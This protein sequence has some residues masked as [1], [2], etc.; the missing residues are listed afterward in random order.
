MQIDIDTY[1]KDSSYV[2]LDI[3]SVNNSS[4]PQPA[5]YNKDLNQPFIYEPEKYVLSVDR[6]ELSVA[7]IVMFFAQD[8]DLQYNIK[9]LL[10]P[11]ITVGSTVNLPNGTAI[12]SVNTI[13]NLLNQR[14]A[15]SYATMAGLVPALAG[16][17]PYGVIYDSVTQLF[18]FYV[19]PA[20]V[21]IVQLCFNDQLREL[22]HGN[23]YSISSLNYCLEFDSGF[24]NSNVVTLNGNIYW[25]NMANY[26][27]IDSWYQVKEIVIETDTLPVDTLNRTSTSLFQAV[28]SNNVL[29]D[30]TV[31]LNYSNSTPSSRLIYVPLHPRYLNFSKTKRILDM[32][33]ISI[34]LYYRTRNGNIFPLVL[35]PGDSFSVLLKFS[36]CIT[37]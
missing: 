21:G 32:K 26:S 20:S 37:N 27:T 36:H 4:T 10:G 3:E 24:E 11:P 15:T 35:N 13:V 31:D 23:F 14:L 8:K 9:T 12:Y 28:S 18:S 19:D 22:F 17:R 33:K 1:V 7:E 5:R 6:V 16:T 25:R 2:Y 29:V 34:N 30:F